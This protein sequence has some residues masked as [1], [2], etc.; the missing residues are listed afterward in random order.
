MTWH[1]F[2]GDDIECPNLRYE[3]SSVRREPAMS[4][5][6]CRRIPTLSIRR[7]RG[8][9]D[10]STQRGGP[11]AEANRGEFLPPI[12]GFCGLTALAMDTDKG[13]CGENQ[14]IF[15]TEAPVLLSHRS[16]LAQRSGESRN[17]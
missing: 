7:W 17:I 5:V 3:L 2:D 1:F 9:R 13:G 14:R 15:N 11:A 12:Q 16:T 4:A 6:R 8:F 10:A